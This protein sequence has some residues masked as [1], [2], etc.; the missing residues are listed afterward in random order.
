[1]S[2]DQRI[3]AIEAVCAAIAD[4]IPAVYGKGKQDERASFW[5]AFQENGRR[6]LYNYAFYIWKDECFYPTYD[7]KGNLLNAFQ[8][9]KIIDL[10]ERLET[11]GVKLDTSTTKS[12]SLCFADN[13][14][15]TRIPTLDLSSCT[16]MSTCFK[17]CKSLVEAPLASVQGVTSWSHAFNGCTSLTDI[18]QEN[19][20]FGYFSASVDLSQTKISFYSPKLSLY[21]WATGDGLPEYSFLKMLMDE[22]GN[23]LPTQTLT[24]SEEQEEQAAQYLLD[25]GTELGATDVTDITGYKTLFEYAFVN[26]HSWTLAI[27]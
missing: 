11:C 4:K 25:H 5:D 16:S 6:T 22:N 14:V 17:G 12:L 15:L 26:G 9:S 21:N 19:D 2:V 24:I 1:M 7:I 13:T 10:T 20:D 23:Q 27:V 8:Y 18:G 3:E